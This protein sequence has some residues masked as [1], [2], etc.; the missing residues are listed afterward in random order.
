MRELSGA[1]IA[2]IDPPG[3]GVP[4]ER[5]VLGVGAERIHVFDPVAANQ[6]TEPE[7]RG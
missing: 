6:A 2:R 7:D 1:S 4:G 5:A 3:R